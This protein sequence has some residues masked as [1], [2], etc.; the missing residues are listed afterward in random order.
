MEEEELS[1]GD[2]DVSSLVLNE[3]MT[4]NK[5]VISSENGKL[6]DY[7]EIYNG[8][9]HEIN[10]KD[11]GLSDEPTVKWVF[12]ETVIGPKEYKLVLKGGST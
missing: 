12:P 8:N 3:V 6:Y 5:G 10:L 2:I 4:S 1:D 11:Y 7:V 9:D